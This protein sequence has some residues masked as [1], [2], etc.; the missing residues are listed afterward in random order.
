MLVTIHID[1]YISKL[2]GDKGSY[3]GSLY[4]SFDDLISVSLEGIGPGKVNNWVFQK[5]A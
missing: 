3:T 1:T 4:I 5:V 2:G